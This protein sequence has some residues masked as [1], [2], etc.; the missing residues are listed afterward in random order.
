MKSNTREIEKCRNELLE[1]LELP[2]NRHCADCDSF[3]K[4][5]I[6]KNVGKVKSTTLDSWTYKLLQHFKA[7]GGNIA[8]NNRYESRLP[9]QDKPTESTDTY[10]LEQFI[11]TKYDAKKWFEH[12]KTEP[13]KKQVIYN[14]FVYLLL[15]NKKRFFWGGIIHRAKNRKTAAKKAKTVKKSFCPPIASF[16]FFLL[17]GYVYL[18]K[19]KETELYNVPDLL[20]ANILASSNQPEEL[21]KFENKNTVTQGGQKTGFDDLLN[22]GKKETVHSGNVTSAFTFLAIGGTNNQTH[23]NNGNKTL[24]FADIAPA[25]PEHKGKDAKH[26]PTSQD[27]DI[28][29]EPTATS[30]KDSIL[31]MYKKQPMLQRMDPDNSTAFMTQL[32]PN[33]NALRTSVNMRSM[34][35]QPQISGLATTC[36]NGNPGSQQPLNPYTIL[37]NKTNSSLF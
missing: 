5:Q 30:A 33:F 28:M 8:V 26:E 21:L 20:P 9:K 18:K 16:F 14:L 32:P 12:S 29:D 11:R 34:G 4:K 31:A 1:L 13:P 19:K 7:Q 23:N 22:I 10:L 27:I 37:N 3:S 15:Q 6:K 25:K 24:G 17:L 35:V 36:F 2:E